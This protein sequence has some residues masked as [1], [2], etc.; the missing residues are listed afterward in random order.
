MNSLL[1]MGHK[2]GDTFRSTVS[3]FTPVPTESRF[4]EEGTQ[5]EIFARII[6]QVKVLIEV[7][8][9]IFL[10]NLTTFQAL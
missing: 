8:N 1:E 9:Y 7:S 4:I 10:L 5:I 3:A 2:M 6:D